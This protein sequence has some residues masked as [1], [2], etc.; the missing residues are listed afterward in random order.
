MIK[1]CT[2]FDR[3]FIH[4]DFAKSNCSYGLMQKPLT[5]VYTAHCDCMAGLDEACSHIAT[6][7]FVVDT[8]VLIR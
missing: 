7:N 4:R 8:T 1:L 3:S 2:L 6:L 5:V